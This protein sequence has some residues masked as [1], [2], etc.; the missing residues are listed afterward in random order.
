MFA[1][2]LF[3]RGWLLQFMVKRIPVRK[4]LL[5]Q[6]FLFTLPQAIAAVFL[7]PIQAYVYIIYSFIAVGLIGGWSAWKTKSI[8]PGLIT[9]TLMN[10]IFVMLRQ[11]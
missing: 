6:A 5:L 11:R 10:L 7:R 3:F 2:E 9:V 8:W 1:E 4:A